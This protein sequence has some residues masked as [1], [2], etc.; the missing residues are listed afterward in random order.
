MDVKCLSLRDIEETFL[1][2][3]HIFV[4]FKAAVENRMTASY[5]YC[6]ELDLIPEKWLASS[7]GSITLIEAFLLLPVLRYC[8]TRISQNEQID[9]HIL[10]RLTRV[11][12]SLSKDATISKAV[13]SQVF[14]ALNLVDSL[15]AGEDIVAFL[16]KQ[17]ISKTILND[18]LERKLEVY[19]SSNRRIELEDVF[20]FA[21]D[22]DNNNGEIKHLI[23][24]FI[25]KFN[26]SIKDFDVEKFAAF[27]TTC[28]ELFE[29]EDVIWGDLLGTNVY[30]NNGDSV[31]LPEIEP[32]FRRVFKFN[33]ICCQ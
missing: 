33:N 30:A 7:D 16:K 28:K 8:K 21:E 26:S 29:N 9:N 13:R 3:K 10:L 27:V 20:W 14:N 1:A 2:L 4:D 15:Q 19:A 6:E 12:S 31:A 5:K 23:D 22:L 32:V 17:G 24:F 25:A 18:E 11:L